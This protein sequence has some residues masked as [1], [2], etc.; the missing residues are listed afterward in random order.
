VGLPEAFEAKI[1]LGYHPTHAELDPRAA[2]ASLRETGVTIVLPRIVGPGAL[3]LHE[4]GPFEGLEEGPH[5]IRQP[6]VTTPE[7][8]RAD[9]DIVIV[10]GV[11]FDASG[12]RIGYG[13]GYYDRLL[14]RLPSARRIGMAFDVQLVGSIPHEPHDCHMHMVVTPTQVVRASGTHDPYQEPL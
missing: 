5:G 4:V 7:V 9:I 2:L 13:G 14:D 6:S 10:P 1:V 3:T 12:A 8:A 11:A